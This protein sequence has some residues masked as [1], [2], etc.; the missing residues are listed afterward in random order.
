M[1]ALELE[2][3]VICKVTTFMVST[4][5]PER[6]GIPDF[7]RPEVENTLRKISMRMHMLC[8]QLD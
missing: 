1:L 6:I 5:Q 3:K 7:Q 8:L 2:G 4:Q